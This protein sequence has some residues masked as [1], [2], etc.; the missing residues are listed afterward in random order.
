MK[1]RVL[2]CLVFVLVCSSSCAWLRKSL[3]DLSAEDVKNAGA[4]QAIAKNLLSSW[5]VNSGFIKGALGSKINEL[6]AHVVSAIGELDALA[7]K[8]GDL[9]AE[10]LGYSVG[11]RVRMLSGIV[12]EAIKLYAP[13]I[14]Q[15]IPSLFAL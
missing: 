1:K 13:E 6:P 8:S 10:E 15:Y 4:T 2:L 11:L 3:V 12:Q 7:K 14:I 9:T 5:P